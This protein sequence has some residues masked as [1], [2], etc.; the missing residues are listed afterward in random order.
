MRQS[1]T[2]KYLG[3]TNTRGSRIVAKAQAGKITIAW[4]HALDSADNHIAAAK[5]FAS[6]YGW[7]GRWVGGALPDGLGYCFVLSIGANDYDFVV[8]DTDVRS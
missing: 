5:A 4:D 8:T 6:K 7:T 1:I 3:P 2:T